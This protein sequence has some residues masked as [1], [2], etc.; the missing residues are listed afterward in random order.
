MTVQELIEKLQELDGNMDVMLPMSSD[1]MN[2]YVDHYVDEVDV[3][4]VINRDPSCD[5]DHRR[6]VVQ[7]R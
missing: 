1:G 7:L 2:H 3:V 6:A 5:S 4:I